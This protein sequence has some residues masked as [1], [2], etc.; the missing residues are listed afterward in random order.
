MG[1]GIDI[2]P[3]AA[4]PFPLLVFSLFALWEKVEV[5]CVESGSVG[6]REDRREGDIRKVDKE[7]LRIPSF[8]NPGESSGGL[9]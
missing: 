1:D 8:V 4:T 6:V 7:A 9:V 3:L 5:F 2:R